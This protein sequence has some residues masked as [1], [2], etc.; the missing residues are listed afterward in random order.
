MR[1]ESLIAVFALSV[2]SFSFFSFKLFAIFQQ[3][4]YR[5]SEFLPV[6]F[7]RKNSEIVR[8]STYSLVFCIV[9]T[10]FSIILKET[11]QVSVYATMSICLSGIYYFK[12]KIIKQAKFT[13]RYI[14]IYFVACLICGFYSLAVVNF[15]WR[16]AKNTQYLACVFL[17]LLPTLTPLFISLS[18]LINLPYDKV[19]Y[20][21][22]KQ[23]CRKRLRHNKK[24]I[25]IG[26]T[27]SFG[28]TSVKEILYKML[29]VKYNVLATPMS[30]NTPLGICK[31]V[32]KD[33]GSF[34]VFIAEMGARYKNDIKELCRLVEP[35][36]GI[37]TGIAEQHTATLGNI[38]DVKMAKNQLIEGL[39]PNGFA[40][41]STQTPL[42]LEMYEEATC[43]KF[44]VGEDPN[45]F[46]R[47]INAQQTESGIEFEF[48]VERKRYKT[49][50]PLLGEHNAINV[51]LAIAVC[52]NLGIEVEKLLAVI[53]TLTPIKHRAQIITTP[54]GVKVIDDGYNANLKG[55]LSTAKSIE[56]F[57]GYKI[58][59]T[60]GIVE[61]G[62]NSQKINTEVGKILAKSFDLVIGVG[63]N[64]RHIQRGV[65]SNDVEFLA[66]KRTED[67]KEI[68]KNR[69][70]AG[71]LV[72]FFNDIPDR[73]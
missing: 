13:K 10:A 50:A 40:V 67:A 37:I 18:T 57:S 70:K 22:S 19:R 45:C 34:D 47:L 41:F 9:L 43:K 16:L 39:L 7:K 60:S 36:V 46:V 11:I 58:A 23:R 8:L 29:S 15:T 52:V 63:A 54:R 31:T 53:P 51:C 68:I 2:F 12:S 17:G 64:A 72:A 24:L 44:L 33:V 21:I 6:V 69:T 35:S 32:K 66:V 26:I 28:K 4:S 3:C 73:Y 25:K 38:Q 71:D 62:K 61:L 27:G 42:S 55:I 30:Y 65:I 5:I 59:V 56:V 1:I 48:E 14:R 49:F 20:E